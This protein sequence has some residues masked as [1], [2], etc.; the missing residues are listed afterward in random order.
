MRFHIP[1]A[2]RRRAARA[3]VVVVPL[4]AVALLV[5]AGLGPTSSAGAYS[6]AQLRLLGIMPSFVHGCH[7]YPVHGGAIAGVEC[8]VPSDHPGVANVVYRQFASFGDLEAAFQRTV[9][10]DLQGRHPASAPCSS[11]SDFL[12]LSDYPIEDQAQSDADAYGS[13]LCWVDHGTPRL[14]WTSAVQLVEAEAVADDTGD[15]ARAGLLSFWEAAG[16]VNSAPSHASPEEVV[17]SL[18]RRYLQREPEGPDVVTYWTGH[19][20]TEGYAR[21]GDE[22]AESSEAQGRFV[23]PLGSS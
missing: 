15:A 1:R 21:V 22:F 8:R 7:P 12:A 9:R 5:H 2:A 13:L 20:N 18:Y 17:R 19:L 10:T 16:P 14:L 11:R 6:L 23:R 3:A 4:G